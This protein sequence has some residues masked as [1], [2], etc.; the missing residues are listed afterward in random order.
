MYV[1]LIKAVLHCRR[2]S[3]D[4]SKLLPRA[5]HCLWAKAASHRL[6]VQ[7]TTPVNLFNTE[8]PI[9]PQMPFFTVWKLEVQGQGVSRVDFFQGPFWAWLVDGLLLVSSVIILLCI[10]MSQLPLFLKTPIPHFTSVSSLKA[11]FPNPITVW[12]L[13]L[14]HVNLGRIQF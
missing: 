2:D 12:G 1:S 8:C 4:S 10:S 11:Q 7:I 13:G 14:Q 9:R 3:K 5:A 6:Q